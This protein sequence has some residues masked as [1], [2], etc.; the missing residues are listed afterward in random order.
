MSNNTNLLD[1][2]T[3]PS[4][5]ARFVVVCAFGEGWGINVDGA[6][7]MVEG[8]ASTPYGIA[9]YNLHDVKDGRWSEGTP[10]AL[11]WSNGRAMAYE[12][13]WAGE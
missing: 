10:G 2:L 4:T 1:A 8:A 9:V 12:P 6:L 5:T 11:V 7:A 3:D 13:T